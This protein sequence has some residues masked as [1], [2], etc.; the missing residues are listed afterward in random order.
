M[1][2]LCNDLFPVLLSSSPAPSLSTAGL[3]HQFTSLRLH[4]NS[5]VSLDISARALVFLALLPHT[6]SSALCRRKQG[7]RDPQQPHSIKEKHI[8]AEIV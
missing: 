7:H 3:I 8:K 2:T 6:S 1:R 4:L 5:L